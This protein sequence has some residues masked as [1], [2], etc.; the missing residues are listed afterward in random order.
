MP[1]E[2]T[3]EGPGT[4][5]FN[6]LLTM[7]SHLGALVHAAAEEL[8]S[9]IPRRFPSDMNSPKCC[10]CTQ[11]QAS[12]LQRGTGETGSVAKGHSA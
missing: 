8:R 10:G 4:G 9:Q 3:Q 2:V 11:A 7:M 12:N 1:I 5:S 6:P